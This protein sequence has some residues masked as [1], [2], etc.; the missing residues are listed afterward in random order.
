MKV[1][2]KRSPL[3]TLCEP[4]SKMGPFVHIPLGKDLRRFPEI[5]RDSD[6][7]QKLY[8]TRYST[9]LPT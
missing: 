1:D 8:K 2:L 6:L 5:P 3:G 4:N 9:T 7:Y